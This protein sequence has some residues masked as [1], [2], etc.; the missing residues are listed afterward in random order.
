MLKNTPYS[1][2]S[3]WFF[4]STAHGPASMPRNKLNI[5]VKIK[6]FFQKYFDFLLT[7][8]LPMTSSANFAFRCTG[9]C[10]KMIAAKIR[11]Q[12][13]ISFA[14]SFCPRINQPNTAENTASKLIIKDATVGL[15]PFCPMICNVY[16]T[17]QDKIPAYKIRIHAE[18][19]KKACAHAL[20]PEM[21]CCISTANIGTA[22]STPVTR[23]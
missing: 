19:D 13:S 4:A 11:Q 14:F 21:E 5:H 2:F 10:A 12:P 3:F 16:P 20:M 18:H 15:S 9:S 8:V 22:V 1:F 7:P 17:P 23:N 6:I